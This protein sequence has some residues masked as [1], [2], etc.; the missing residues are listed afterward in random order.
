MTRQ[1]KNLLLVV[2]SIVLAFACFISV[3]P[4]GNKTV[5]A[6]TS[7]YNMIAGAQARKADDGTA[8]LRFV[9][10]MDASAYDADN[11]ALSYGM[12]IAPLD[13]IQDAE[14]GELT[15]ESVFGASA[16][17]CVDPACDKKCGK[18]IIN[19]TSD[20]LVD[21]TDEVKKAQ[22]ESYEEG[23]QFVG[24]K[25]V[26]LDIKE[27]NYLRKFVGVAYI[28]DATDPENVDYT[29]AT[30]N[31]E[32][33][34]RSVAYVAQKSLDAGV[35]DT[36]N[37]CL[38]NY[39]AKSYEAIEFDA[40]V[41]GVALNET[42]VAEGTFEKGEQFVDAGEVTVAIKSGLEAYQY[43]GNK[44]L[45]GKAIGKEI[46]L[47]L[48][49]KSSDGAYTYTKDVTAFVDDNGYEVLDDLVLGLNKTDSTVAVEGTSAYSMTVN[50]V[51]VATAP[52]LSEGVLTIA[53]SNFSSES[54]MNA[55]VLESDQAKY[56]L[57]AEVY[58]YAI[59]TTA[60]FT[61]WYGSA[62]SCEPP[63]KSAFLTANIDLGSTYMQINNYDD[64][65]SFNTIF[66]GKGH[67]VSGGK[68]VYGFLPK[69]G[70]S[71]V[72]RNV[73]LVNFSTYGNN[74]QGL[75]GVM[76]AGTIENCYFQGSRDA[77]SGNDLSAFYTEIQSQTKIKNVVVIGE[78]LGTSA[79]YKISK[80][81]YSGVH[82]NGFYVVNN[83]GSKDFNENSSSFDT[84]GAYTSTEEFATV[85]NGALP[86]GLSSDFWTIGFDGTP[87][88]VTL[89]VK[90]ANQEIIIDQAGAVEL[91]LSP[92]HADLMAEISVNDVVVDE[93]AIDSDGVV[94]IPHSSLTSFGSVVIGIK[95]FNDTK[96]AGTYVFNAVIY[97]KAI[98]T[99]DEFVA[100]YNVNGDYKGIQGNTDAVLLTAD[101]DLSG[102]SL[103]DHVGS[104]V[105]STNGTGYGILGVF[106][107]NGHVISNPT[108][109]RGFIN[110]G[111]T[112][113]L[114]N[115]IVTGA[116]TKSTDY[117]GLAG[118]YNFGTVQ[119]CYFQGSFSATTAASRF[120]PYYGVG[121]AN[122]RTNGVIVVATGGPTVTNADYGYG[123]DYSTYNYLYV[124]AS[125]A[126]KLLSVNAK[127]S[128]VYAD[129]TAFA[130]AC[131]GALPAGLS[132]DF[133]TL[134]K[135]GAPTPIALYE[136]NNTVQLKDYAVGL[137]KQEDLKVDLG[138]ANAGKTAKLTLDGVALSDAIV[139]ENGFIT[140]ARA[141]FT[142]KG[143]K[144][145]K[146]KIVSE[147]S[148]AFYATNVDVVD[149]AIATV[150]EFISWYE[151][152]F[153]T[154]TESVAL[155]SDIILPTT[156]SFDNSSWYSWTSD[157]VG[158]AGTFNGCG[159]VIANFKSSIGFLASV[160]SA[161]VIKNL[162]LVNMSTT[163]Q[164]SNGVL[165][166]E[167]RGTITDCYFQGTH[168]SG[169]YGVMFK[170]AGGK[171]FTNV[172]LDVTNSSSSYAIEQKD[173]GATIWN[174]KINNC[175][176]IAD[177]CNGEFYGNSAGWTMTNSA[178]YA[179]LEAMMAEVTAV[180]ASYSATGADWTYDATYGLI[181]KSALAYKQ[182]QA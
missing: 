174:K 173:N 96:L 128:A 169:T 8:G 84:W 154:S 156:K 143:T 95:V 21:V 126:T 92:A 144:T 178:I 52:T 43:V 88:P 118:C 45:S 39:V 30:T 130:T 155:T 105:W 48:S 57:D 101:I 163:T 13:Y 182:A 24:F 35:E 170:R 134:D 97:N 166:W 18:H 23:T 140:V 16:T 161:G 59:G 19:L 74:R 120:A 58:D 2:L 76:A 65:K 110:V 142:E 5:S 148:I 64:T 177:N 127:N 159:H 114:K 20:A 145:L 132:S 54:L 75:L 28:K 49:A 106:N 53:N 41:T 113:I 98:S 111:D 72:V 153:H 160:K 82:T 4:I 32:E 135:D 31:Q 165:G 164:G 180:P 157:S 122:S 136:K 7:S 61:A 141:N 115:L 175:Y 108:T 60:E 131:A 62:G 77:T 123:A 37:G 66:D 109:N 116:V 89:P 14:K 125:T 27:A 100:W 181:M 6:D 78:E 47:T 121:N 1:R 87:I 147:N 40:N 107:G 176:I 67:A 168:L 119:N 79:T 171:P 69:L 51:E 17:Y 103:S 85:C 179:S 129:R 38:A 81:A 73:A 102:K 68:Y 12:L 25:G 91:N 124:V 139:D 162:A 29:F 11:D 172:V 9:S 56:V 10:Y 99:A 94:S 86:A 83:N 63:T 137:N 151:N 33:N 80:K 71:A 112:G 3:M 55:V 150:D 70:T 90:L 133:W 50:G 22:G 117:G 44:V 138:V 42:I 93:I 104:N 36:A 26:I 146:I 158:F 46:T 152:N 34:A 149:I 167:C 15:K